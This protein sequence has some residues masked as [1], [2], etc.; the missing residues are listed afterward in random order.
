MSEANDNIAN[1]DVIIIGG[2]IVGAACAYYL[3]S[4]AQVIVLEREQVFGYHATGRSAALFSEYLGDEI[5][6]KLTRLSRSLFFETPEDLISVPLLHR[7]GTLAL[8]TKQELDD[9]TAAAAVEA[10]QI[11]TEPPKLID[12]EHART[13]CPILRTDGYAAAI[14]RTATWDIDV[15]GLLQV[16]RRGARANGAQYISGVRIA[17][18]RQQ[19]KLWTILGSK[20]GQ[21]LSWTVPVVINAGGAWA[22]EVAQMAGVTQI[23]MIPKRRTIVH[24]EVP[25][26]RSNAAD[27]EWHMV[28]DLGSTFY[29]RQENDGVIS[30]PGD[31][32]P[33]QPCDA[34]PEE[35]DVARAIDNIQRLTRLKVERISNKWAGL[36]TFSTDE[37]PVLGEGSDSPGFYWAAGLGGVGVQ[38][39]PAVGRAIAK[40]VLDNRLPNDFTQ[41][42]LDEAL[43]SPNRFIQHMN[44]NKEYCS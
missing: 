18:I 1:A 26:L 11:A 37:Q 40:L 44:L 10:G 3:S 38:T 39:S 43:F 27:K 23:G 31:A 25:N 19:N 5:T 24:V 29:F 41:L 6:R 30:C 9:G 34:Q 8:V 33:C 35:L 28:T 21:D 13:L 4:S 15:D 42:G 14:N 2:G 20:A 17:S 22:D 36:R 32:T 16:Y 12:L 7:R